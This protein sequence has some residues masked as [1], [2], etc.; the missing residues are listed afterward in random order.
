[1]CYREVSQVF[2][3]EKLTHAELRIEEH[4]RPSSCF[5]FRHKRAVGSL[6]KETALGDFEGLSAQGP[7]VI[8]ATEKFPISL[9]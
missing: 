9:I 2:A 5:E 3:W 4:R 7:D 6:I 8:H 1:V